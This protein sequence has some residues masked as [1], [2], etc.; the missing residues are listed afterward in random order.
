VVSDQAF[1]DFGMAATYDRWRV[2]LNLEAPLVGE[3]QWGT[4][5]GVEFQHP[6][7]DLGFQPDVLSDARIGIDGRLWG[8]PG[9]PFRLGASAQLFIPSGSRADYVTDG[10]YRAMGR[11]LFAGD[12]RS[13]TY[14]GQLGVHIRPLDDASTPGSPRGSELLFG[15]AAGARFPVGRAAA[16]N[17]T[18]GSGAAANE[19]VRRDGRKV[20]VVGPEI[21]GATAFVDFLGPT[22]TAVEG[23]LTGRFEGT[24]THGGQLRLKLGIGAGLDPHFGGPAYRFVIGVEVFDHG[25]AR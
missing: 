15:L 5:G 4:V 3:G 21:Y 19:T 16:A 24:G 17:E 10:T 22:R 11:V 25:A 1:A 7:L 12:I 14:A 13:L 8:E 23:L 18:V 2:Y 9:G 20:I 6:P